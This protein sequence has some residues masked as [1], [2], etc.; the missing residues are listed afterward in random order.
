MMIKWTFLGKA[1][2]HIIV[3]GRLDAHTSPKLR[4]ALKEIEERGHVLIYLEMDK[5]DFMDS[6]GL[7]A[8]VSALKTARG[9]GGDLCLVRP[10]TA[11]CTVLQYTLLDKIIPAVDSL[12]EAKT[13][14][15]DLEV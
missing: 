11:V 9:R 12:E 4:N 2:A 13:Q 7:A 10:S 14:F 8:I 5:V 3:E 6:S 15:V 1:Q